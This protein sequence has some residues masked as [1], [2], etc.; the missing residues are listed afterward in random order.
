MKTYLILWDTEKAVLTG[1]LY[2]WVL[3]FKNQ[4]PQVNN[5]RM[6]HKPW[7]SKSKPNQ[8]SV[9]GKNIKIRVETNEWKWKNNTKDQWNKELGLWKDKQDWETLTK[10]TKNQGED[11][12]Q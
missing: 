8:K 7:K 9:E 3:T 2:L 6:H 11:P 1:S 5:L 4:R 12:N 10:L